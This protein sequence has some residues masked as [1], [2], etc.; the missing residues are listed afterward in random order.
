[1]KRLVLSLIAA[2]AVSTLFAGGTEAKAGEYRFKAKHDHVRKYCV[3]ELV[4]NDAGVEFVTAEEGHSRKWLYA[5]V[6]LLKLVSP[7]ELRVL[8]YENSRLKVG[9][10]DFRFELTE[11][12]LT[13]EVSD[14]VLSKV[15][16]PVSTSFVPASGEE[17]VYSIPVRHRR[18]IG[19]DEGVLKVY[20][21]G[22]AY[23]SAGGA[24]DSRYWRWTDIQGVGRSG[25][26]SLSV[27]TYEPE[28]GGP[29]KS[30][31]FD[32]KGRAGD[33]VYDYMWDR[34]NG[35]T[36]R[37]PSAAGVATLTRVAPREKP[38]PKPAASGEVTVVG[39]ISDS[40]CGLTHHEGMDETDCV[41]ACAKNGRFVLADRENKRVY[42]LDDGAQGTAKKF[43]N[44]KV[45]ITGHPVGQGIHVMKIEPA[46]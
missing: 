28:L 32:L 44:R 4:I 45:R 22:V 46:S 29:T 3:G 13:K 11:G 30:F 42:D 9:D 21:T 40:A 39:Y 36:G 31:D 41:L 15:A 10:R 33:E 8:S 34:V 23:E 5:D 2:L 27:K 17:P 1:M 6:K 7:T 35:V 24:D 25:K 12:Q 26:F 38:A 16:R 37:L 20:P 19:G 18:R 14:F 43:A